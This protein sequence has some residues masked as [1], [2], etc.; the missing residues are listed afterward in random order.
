M[1]GSGNTSMKRGLR[2]GCGNGAG[3]VAE[4]MPNEI[5]RGYGTPAFPA[6]LGTI[7]IK[8]DATMGTASHYRCTAETGTWSPMSDD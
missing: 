3:A 4:L 8:L 5:E 1:V 6:P 2:K 7:Y